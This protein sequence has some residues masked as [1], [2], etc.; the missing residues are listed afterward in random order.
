MSPAQTSLYFREWGAVRRHYTEAGIDPKLADAKRHELHQKALGY[1]KSSKDF[2]NAEFDK[3]LGVFR[4]ITRP[5]DLSAQLRQM[6]Q[7]ELR[8]QEARSA[9]LQLLVDLGIGKDHDASQGDFVRRQYL[10]GIVKKI[11]RGA[12]VDFQGLGDR[13]ANAILHTLR[14]RLLSRERA[15]AKANV[16]F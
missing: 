15:M 6:D 9:C 14:M 2:T 11:T 3:V 1:R 12:Q 5:D 7:P 4:A 16:P 13:Q 8:M 10:D